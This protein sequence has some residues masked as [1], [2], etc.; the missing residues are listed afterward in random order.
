VVFGK[1]IFYQKSPYPVALDATQS[2]LFEL[3]NK[4]DDEA[5]AKYVRVFERTSF[6]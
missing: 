2:E 1:G 3:K 6:N 5:S 4:Y